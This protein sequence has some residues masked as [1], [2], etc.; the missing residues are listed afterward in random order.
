MSQGRAQKRH[1]E[2]PVNRIGKLCRAELRHHQHLP[3]RPSD[4]T[5]KEWKHGVLRGASQRAIAA[6]ARAVQERRRRRAAV[7]ARLRLLLRLGWAQVISN[8]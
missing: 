2:G 5:E 7:L 6:A 8:Q 3:E 1:E 4:R